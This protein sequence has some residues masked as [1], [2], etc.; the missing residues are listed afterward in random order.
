MQNK[1]AIILK[2]L[3]YDTHNYEINY[4]QG[5]SLALKFESNPVTFKQLA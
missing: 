5:S 4:D 1:V 3:P 2:Y